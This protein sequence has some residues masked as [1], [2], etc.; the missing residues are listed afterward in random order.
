MQQYLRYTLI[1]LIPLVIGFLCY[2]K[3]YDSGFN[4]KSL[5]V[6]ESTLFSINESII[7]FNK[8]TVE[9]EKENEEF[10]VKLEE[11][12]TRDVEVYKEVIKYVEKRDRSINTIDSDWLRIYNNSL[13]SSG[14]TKAS[15]KN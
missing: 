6:A 15:N 7:N 5:E 2:K 11:G 10:S 8:T 13:T 3:G 12:K 4:K 14:E 1:A 9:M